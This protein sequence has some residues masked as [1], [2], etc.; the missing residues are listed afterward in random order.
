MR[1]IIQDARLAASTLMADGANTG[2]T[3]VIRGADELNA[4]AD[5]AVRII[6][7]S[8]D[9]KFEQL[10]PLQ[11]EMMLGVARATVAVKKLSEKAYTA[12]DTIALDVRSILGSFPLVT[13]TF[14][15]QRVGGLSHLKRETDY[16]MQ[17]IGSYVGLPATGYEAEIQLYIDGKK[18]DGLKRNPSEV[19]VTELAIPSDVINPLFK[20]DKVALVPVDVEVTYTSPKPWYHLFARADK[21]PIVTRV[22]LA[23]YPSHVGSFDVSA[24]ETVF[25]WT[26]LPSDFKQALG[27]NAHCSSD[28]GKHYGIDA[29]VEMVVSGGEKPQQVPGDIRIVN[30]DCSPIP[31]HNGFDVIHGPVIQDNGTRAICRFRARSHPSEYRLTVYRQ[32]W[33]ATGD[34]DVKTAVDLY[35]D[36]VS[37]IRVPK[38]AKAVR[39][40]GRDT[41]GSRFEFMLGEADPSSPVQLVSKQENANDLSYF[42]R[43]VRPAELD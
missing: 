4:A 9:K 12:K 37:E 8:M 10:E 35:F 32:L 3:L 25:G 23:L 42:V 5:N 30:A 29:G 34:R 26:P 1:D 22:H 18:V 13:E 6:G 16:R 38:F 43:A 39:V 28:C 20:D 36:K 17:L 27:P 7:H 21:S 33:A 11:K 2:N 31:G 24:R 41:S 40:S 19:H 15:L 14:V